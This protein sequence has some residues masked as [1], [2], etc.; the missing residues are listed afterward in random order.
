MDS[1]HKSESYSYLLDRNS[2]S[3]L[4]EEEGE[5]GEEGMCRVLSE[6]KRKQLAEQQKRIIAGLSF[7]QPSAPSSHLW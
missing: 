7:G 6:S 5:E 1:G 4:G 2:S 3:S